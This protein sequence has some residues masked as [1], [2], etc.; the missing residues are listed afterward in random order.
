MPV[1]RSHHAAKPKAFTLLELI[2]VM[3]ILCTVLAMAAPSLK[4]FFSSRQLNDISEQILTMTRYAKVHSVFEG[5]PYRIN[6]DLSRRYYW[7]SSLNG[8]QYE[9]LKNNFGR[10][11]SIPTEIDVDFKDLENENGVYYFSFSPQGYSKP[12]RIRLEDNRDNI[13][14]IVC[15]SPIE[16]YE[17]VKIYNGQ[18]D[19]Q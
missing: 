16:N 19:A 14:E 17:I 1:N 5:N 18:E 6:F 8:S 11:F 3:I 7:L 12:S 15:Y 4:G 10:Y 2:L 13:L 9:R